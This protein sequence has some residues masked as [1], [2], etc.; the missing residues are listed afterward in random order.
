MKLIEEGYSEN[1]AFEM[2]ESEMASVFD[3][4]REESRI[5]RGF[6]LNNRARS[7]LNY[8]Q[9]LAEVEGR[10]KVQQMERDLNKYITQENRWSDLLSGNQEENQ[11]KMISL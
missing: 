2:V 11:K 10:A 9:Q 5:L 3:K 6:A 4:Q 1:K 7:Y 8:S